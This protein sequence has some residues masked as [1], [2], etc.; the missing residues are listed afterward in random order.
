MKRLS[1]LVTTYEPPDGE[2]LLI[3]TI[4]DGKAVDLQSA[5]PVVVLNERICS[6]EE[7][8]RSKSKF[9]D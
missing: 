3:K 7:N 2:R 5:S 8:V 9:S 4:S 6:I 1:D